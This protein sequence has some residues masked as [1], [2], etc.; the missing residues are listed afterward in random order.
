[1]D[2]IR[3]DQNK[4]RDENFYIVRGSMGDAFNPPE[5]PTHYYEVRGTGQFM[6][7]DYALTMDYVPSYI[8][9]QI[10]VM[11]AEWRENYPV[12]DSEWE[13]AVYAYMNHCYYADESKTGDAV[14]YGKFSN[15]ESE[16]SKHNPDLHYAV[17]FIRQ[18]YPDYVPNLSLMN[19]KD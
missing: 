7:L 2:I 16:E 3:K 12:I 17:V 6:N 10:K 9:N 15:N 18:F 11:I 8:K 19:R 1:M 4:M 13:S 5:Y 14:V